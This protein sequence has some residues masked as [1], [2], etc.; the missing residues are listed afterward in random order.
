MRCGC[1]VLVPARKRSGGGYGEGA[2]EQLSSRRAR[3]PSGF[4]DRSLERSLQTGGGTTDG[5]ERDPLLVVRWRVRHGERRAFDV[6]PDGL[7]EQGRG[8]PLG[9]HESA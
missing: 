6:W 7:L 2:G 9:A 1:V 4:G 3:V 8:P 5:R